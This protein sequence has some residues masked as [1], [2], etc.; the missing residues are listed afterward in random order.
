MSA[1]TQLLKDKKTLL[2]V[3]AA[4]VVLGVG[5]LALMQDDSSS[6]PAVELSEAEKKFFRDND[7]LK[8]ERLNAVLSVVGYNYI[9]QNKS[10]PKG[11]DAGWKSVLDTVS[12][13]DSFTDPYT[14]TIY[15]YTDATPDYGEIQ[16]GPGMTCDKKK[17][18][19][20]EGFGADS[21]AF[22]AKFSD[23]IR[24]ISNFQG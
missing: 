10:L 13:T 1:I 9:S 8:E 15:K 7:S 11:D 19:F 20:I 14:T 18:A 16:Y 6:K 17:S 4:V 5:G 3:G 24:C 22:R 12:I 21:L 23:G 2:I